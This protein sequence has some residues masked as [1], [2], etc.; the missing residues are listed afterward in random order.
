MTPPLNVDKFIDDIKNRPVLWHRDYPTVKKH[1]QD[2]WTDISICHGIPQRLLKT[3]WKTLRDTFRVEMKKIPKD[4]NGEYTIPPTSYHS[5]WVHYKQMSF[6]AGQMRGR[7]SNAQED[8][9]HVG[10]ITADSGE[11][12]AEYNG[13]FEDSKELLR[14]Q[15]E[16]QRQRKQPPLKPRPTAKKPNYP[17]PSRTSVRPKPKPPS[18]KPIITTTT[19]E[20]MIAS[21]KLHNDEESQGSS[22]TMPQDDDYYF[23]MSLHPYLS[24]MRP[25]QKLQ[26]RMEIQNVLFKRLYSQGDL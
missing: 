2:A 4:A 13:G 21:P 23:L 7:T 19:T 8:A 20:T 18:P 1:L 5:Q 12:Y 9:D 25:V 3:K 6:L 15:L 17:A 22:I 10:Y 11:D 24:Q 16:E 14:Q 26:A